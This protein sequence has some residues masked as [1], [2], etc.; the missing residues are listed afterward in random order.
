MD[1][2]KK[3]KFTDGTE[4]PVGTIYCIGQ[5]YAKHALE[6]GSTVAENPTIFI[7]PPSAFIEDNEMIVLP[8]FSSNVHYEVELVVLIGK[9]CKEIDENLAWEYIA[10][11]AVGIDVTLRDI[12][13]QAKKEGKPWAVAKGFF[14]S[15]P[16]SKFIKQNVFGSKIP[17][18]DLKLYVN[19]ELKQ[20]G[21]TKEMERTVANLIKYLANVFSLRK[22]DLIFTG[23][24]AGVG[25]I[26]T[27]DKIEAELTGFSKLYV[28]V[29]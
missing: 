14:S 20:Y 2:Y 19:N 23:T 18:F 9:D 16:I 17:F 13:N 3:L 21:S 8:D 12:Q 26:K 4:Y 29:K 1:N 11:Y 5:N 22:G 15:A 25:Q 27:G 7:K 28:G 6:M 10:G 24:P